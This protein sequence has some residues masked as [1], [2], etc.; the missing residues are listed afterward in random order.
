[1][2]VAFE[3]RKV[4]MFDASNGHF[5][6]EFSFLDNS[7]DG[8][9][10]QAAI[11]DSDSKKDRDM[12]ADLEARGR[13]ASPDHASKKSPRQKS[14]GPRNEDDVL[15]DMVKGERAKQTKKNRIKGM[16]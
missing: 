11:Q 12:D 8:R 3:N 10:G 13:S 5:Q 4:K 2:L 16:N 9:G 7:L 1:M 14:G 15:G 6:Y